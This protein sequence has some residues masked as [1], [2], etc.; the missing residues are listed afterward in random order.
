VVVVEIV[1]G[2]M[3][4]SGGGRRGHFGGVVR[5]RP[6][7]GVWPRVAHAGA[8]GVAAARAFVMSFLRHRQIY[9]SDLASNRS[10]GARPYSASPRVPSF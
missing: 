10:A 1:R 2:D 5:A 6:P 9:Q 8:P 3:L 4:V 7:L